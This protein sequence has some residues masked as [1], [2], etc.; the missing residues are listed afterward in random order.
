MA[1]GTGSGTFTEQDFTVPT[2]TDPPAMALDLQRLAVAGDER[3]TQFTQ[4]SRFADWDST[5]PPDEVGT[6]ALLRTI[7]SGT[8]GPF[9]Q[10][11]EKFIIWSGQ[12]F[13]NTIPAGPSVLGEL[14]LPDQDQRYWWWV[15]CNLIF[16]QTAANTR[17]RTNLYVH[18]RD[19]ATGSLLSTV[20][21][22]NAYAIGIGNEMILFD[23]FVR[24]GGGKLRA[25]FTQ[26]SAASLNMQA[27][28]FLWAVRVAPDRW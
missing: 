4:W 8:V 25:G 24:S 21:A 13:D 11:V 14:T 16:A 9:V 5:W 23:A 27:G 19:P 18:D 15:G 7:V 17:L 22:N 26:A 20:Y 2:D 12:I 28:S 6:P 10:N 1:K 3:L